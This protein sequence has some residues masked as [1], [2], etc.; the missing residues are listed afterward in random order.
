MSKKRLILGYVFFGIA[1]ALTIIAGYY[2]FKIFSL[3]NIGT[4]EALGLIVLLPIYFI[5]LA[6]SAICSL[7]A[8][9]SLFGFKNMED[10]SKRRIHKVFFIL[11]ICLFVIDIAMGFTF[12][13]INRK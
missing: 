10:I 4:T 7:I 13:L 9:V 11:S 5:L 1:I 6:L 8:L 2:A 3:I 12:L